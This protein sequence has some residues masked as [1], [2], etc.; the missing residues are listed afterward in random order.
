[1]NQTLDGEDSNFTNDSVKKVNEIFYQ[2]AR[3][4]KLTRK[5]T[6]KHNISK[7]KMKKSNKKWF[8]TDCQTCLNNLKFTSKI[9]VL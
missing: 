5:G 8:D 3:L 7:K 6:S 9:N 2:S 4:A 1:M